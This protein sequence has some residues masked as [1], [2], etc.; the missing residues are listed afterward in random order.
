MLRRSYRQVGDKSQESYEETALVEFS[1]Y[2]GNARFGAVPLCIAFRV[3]AP[4][5]FLRTLAT[6]SVTGERLLTL[7]Q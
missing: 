3:N 2:S 5:E 4:L 7:R 1:L 6:L